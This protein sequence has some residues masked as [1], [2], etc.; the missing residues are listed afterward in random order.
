MNSS[1]T[2]NVN[3]FFESEGAATAQLLKHLDSNQWLLISNDTDAIL[4]ALL[5][6]IR[7]PRNGNLFIN[8]F[9]LQLNFMQN[10]TGVCG[11]K[12]DKVSEFWDINKLIYTIEEILGRINNK[13]HPVYS[14]L[15]VY[16]ATGSDMTDKWYQKT[17]DKF[18]NAWL[19]NLHYIG[20]LVNQDADGVHVNYQSYRRLLHAV[21]ITKNVD[22]RDIS[23]E[24]LRNE[25]RKRKDILLHMPDQEEILQIGLL[26]SGSFRYIISYISKLNQIDW[27]SYGYDFVR[28][29]GRIYLFYFI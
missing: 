11:T 23:F 25:C 21:W 14:I 16:L 10:K 22:P 7:R 17:H 27:S 20:E 1:L 15:A 8:N 19:L 26:V 4:Y 18:M 24:E 6:G 3:Y 13:P 29:E 2:D 28:N 12:R 5:A 9:W